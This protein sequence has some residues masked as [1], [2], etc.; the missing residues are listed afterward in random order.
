[1]TNTQ[2]LRLGIAATP[3][4][5]RITLCATKRHVQPRPRRF[6]LAR[7]QS[8]RNLPTKQKF[9]RILVTSLSAG[10]A[11]GLSRVIVMGHYAEPANHGGS[12]PG[13]MVLLSRLWPAPMAVVYITRSRSGL[14]SVGCA[15]QECPSMAHGVATPLAN[16]CIII[17]R[18][19]P[20]SREEHAPKKR[21]MA[22]NSASNT[23]AKNEG[24]RRLCRD[25]Q[26][27]SRNK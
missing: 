12:Q 13:L 11:S 7:V 22:I 3:S 1:M 26:P 20:D 19:G 2:N 5:H 15:A 8:Y 27:T 25:R 24:T 9:R 4:A 6:L 23:A 21:S 16:A 18:A 17:A 10:A 14:L